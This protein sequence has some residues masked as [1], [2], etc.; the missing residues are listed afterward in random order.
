[1]P[2][3]TFPPK[4]DWRI[5]FDVPHTFQ[6][7]PEW[8]KAL[9]ASNFHPLMDSFANTWR[10]PVNGT[11]MLRPS[12][13][14][15]A[16]YNSAYWHG[17]DDWNFTTDSWEKVHR[18]VDPNEV[19]PILRYFSTQ[20][21]DN[22]L[23][24]RLA[25]TLEIMKSRPSSIPTDELQ[26]VLTSIFTMVRDESFVWS[27]GAIGD[28]IHRFQNWFALIWD[29]IQIVFSLDGTVDVYRNT[30]GSGADAVW[31]FLERF[32]IASPGDLMKDDGHFI[33][34]PMPGI[35][36]GIYHSYV[37][38]RLDNASSV[39]SVGVTRG[40][41]IPF[42]T[43]TDS[44]VN[45]ILDSST[46]KVAVLKD[47]RIMQ[48]KLGYHQIQFPSSG[49]YIDD[50]IDPGY[51]PSHTPDILQP[52]GLN[53]G[54]GTVSMVL[55]NTKGTAD[56]DP[57]GSLPTTPPDRQGRAQLTLATTDSKYTPFVTSYAVIWEGVSATR[58]TTAIFPDKLWGLAFSEDQDEK[59]EGT[60][61]VMMK[62]ADQRA[63]VERGDTTF[64]LEKS[65]ND[66]TT[67]TL[68]AGGLAK[69]SDDAVMVMDHAGAYYVSNWTLTDMHG[70]FDEVKKFGE[71]AFDGETV[72]DAINNVLRMSTLPP[73]TSLPAASTA[74]K[75]PFISGQN[76]RYGW[77]IGDSGDQAISQ[78]LLLM[79]KQFEE[80]YYHYNWQ[81]DTSSLVQRPFNTASGNTWTL[82]PY[83]DEVDISTRNVKLGM[84]TEL[85]RVTVQPPEGNIVQPFGITAPDAKTARVPGKPVV[86]VDS[87]YEPTSP[88]YLGRTK[89]IAPYFCP[90]SDKDEIDRMGR[91]VYA[92]ACHR[93][94]L[95][96]A[97]AFDFVD[98]F[99]P[100]ALVIIRG[101]DEAG[102]RANLFGSLANVRYR[103]NAAGAAY[104]GFW[105]KR[106]S[107]KIDYQEDGQAVTRVTY[108]MDSIWEGEIR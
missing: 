31:V 32:E 6:V 73:I 92:A 53:T 37:S 99:K 19:G 11:L 108:I 90:V 42:P 58:A 81:T 26:E 71:T 39:A 30:G 78:L 17:L 79:R 70:R 72:G 54:N 93:R 7:E 45:Y 24:A 2:T 51:Q 41:I 87:I 59:F 38:Q 86:N 100:N 23:I 22:P 82:T 95:V 68:H 101:E 50:I 97:Q 15:E 36:I 28:S 55:K 104:S 10:E 74:I 35:G 14:T 3:R 48:H 29:I 85:L 12:F 60:C 75:L 102:S 94:L 40:H 76:W 77:K 27:H 56:W 67:W 13:L 34:I 44:G 84:G 91:R 21:P 57:I 4:T 33:I 8:H 80:W 18:G 96:T 107:V 106:R 49:T 46:L 64:Q 1:M 105:L 83:Q 16:W 88:D 66:G 61:T 52:N 5:K 98:G 9:N 65:T 43:R 62:G 89:W 63:L 25:G 47:L 20:Y 69:L 103:T